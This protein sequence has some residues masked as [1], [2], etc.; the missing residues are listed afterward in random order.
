MRPSAAERGAPGG[1][2]SSF[3]TVDM[4]ERLEAAF[5]AVKQIQVSTEYEIYSFAEE[6]A[7]IRSE[8]EG[9]ED[10]LARA[11][12]REE[13]SETRR[14][15][16]VVLSRSPAGVV[17]VTAAH[18]AFRPDTVVEHFGPPS[19]AVDDPERRIRSVSIK[20]LQTNWVLGLP[21]PRTFELLAWDSDE[22]VALLAVPALEPGGLE[23]VRP[24]PVRA[25]DP[26]DLGPGSFVYILGYP[27]GYRMVSRGIATPRGDERGSF[28]IDGNWN[29]GVSGGAVLAVRGEE[30]GLEW[31]GM[32]RAASAV[33][34][35]RLVPPDAATDGHD[36]AVPY[37]G[38]IFLEEHLRI[39]YGVTLSVPMTTIR[40]FIEDNRESVERRGYEVPVP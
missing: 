5:E 28:V 12:F 22:D 37:E 13:V 20:R 25:G 10:L 11:A 36:P 14:A 40:R 18:A 1:Y 34:E 19:G 38:P 32:A 7:P 30:E 8:L 15:T 26:S 33:S 29:Q 31:I 6:S 23:E 27:G 35:P 24:L 9:G 4:A 21:G 17:L 39:Q 2:R 16:A 3:P